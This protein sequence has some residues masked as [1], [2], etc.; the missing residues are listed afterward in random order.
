VD[1]FGFQPRQV[2]ELGHPRPAGRRDSFQGCNWLNVRLHL[3]LSGYPIAKNKGPAR[4]R[5]EVRGT[6]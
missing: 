3:D 6:V 5:F 4:G 1:A 2:R